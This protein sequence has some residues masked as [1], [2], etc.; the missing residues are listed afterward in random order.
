M[1]IAT[2]NKGHRTTPLCM[3]ITMDDPAA[4]VLVAPKFPPEFLLAMEKQST[5]VSGIGEDTPQTDTYI[6]LPGG[7]D[8]ALQT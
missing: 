4:V 8:T 6:K 7:G 1:L 2:H 3:A 5:V